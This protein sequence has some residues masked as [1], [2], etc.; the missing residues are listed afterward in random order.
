VRAVAAHRLSR[1]FA[2]NRERDGT[3]VATSLV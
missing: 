2:L 3:A 1:A